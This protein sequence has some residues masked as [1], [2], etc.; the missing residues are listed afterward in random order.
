[1]ANTHTPLHCYDIPEE[2][3]RVA[4]FLASDESSYLNG[5]IIVAVGGITIKR[6]LSRLPGE[7]GAS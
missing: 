7:G 3:A 2:I 6:D 5:T 4:R 1:M